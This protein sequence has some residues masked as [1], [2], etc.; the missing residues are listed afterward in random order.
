[1]PRFSLKLL[2]AL[3][4]LSCALLCVFIMNR[5]NVV[6]QYELEVTKDALTSLESSF[7]KVHSNTRLAEIE[8]GTGMVL[9]AQLLKDESADPIL[10][11]ALGSISEKPLNC[12]VKTFPDMP[13]TRLFVFSEL[14]QDE[15]KEGT[16]TRSPLKQT[17]SVCILTRADNLDPIDFVDQQGLGGLSYMYNNPWLLGWTQDDG[18]NIEYR[19]TSSGFKK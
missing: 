5:R 10:R 1:M 12:S 19:V 6:L 3:I 15:I 7:E 2:L 18:T 9:L 13:N 16:V 17:I 4:T 14:I 8:A 11:K